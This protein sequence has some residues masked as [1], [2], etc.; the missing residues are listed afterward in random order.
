MKFIYALML[1]FVPAILCADFE[2]RNTDTFFDLT[3]DE[4]EEYMQDFLENVYSPLRRKNMKTMG[5][6]DMFTLYLSLKMTKPDVVIESAHRSGYLTD[7]VR[8][9]LGDD[10]IIL[11]LGLNDPSVLGV[12]KDNNQH[13]IYKTGK[14]QIDLSDIDLNAYLSMFSKD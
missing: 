3:T 4:V 12:K 8:R 7:L 2:V 1:F 9:T 13:T 14:D 10:C 6:T 5:A 11:C